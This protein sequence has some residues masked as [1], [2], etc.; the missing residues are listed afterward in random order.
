M[1]TLGE[2]L[3]RFDQHADAARNRLVRQL[4]LTGRW[5][6]VKRQARARLIA[7]YPE[8]GD[9]MFRADNG[10]DVLEELADAVNYAVADLA[11]AHERG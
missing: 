6:R 9:A 3:I 4:T 7:G 5:E 8:F 2:Q 11:P 1:L 10:L